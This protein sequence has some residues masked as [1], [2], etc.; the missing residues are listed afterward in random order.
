[1]A[2]SP[3]LGAGGIVLR[4]GGAPL[5]AVV[6]RRKDNAWVLPKGKLKRNESA[7]AAAEREVQEE[8]GHDVVVHE[9]VGAISYTANRKPK[10]V[11]FWRM[12]AEDGAAR[13]LSKDIRAVKWLPLNSA[14]KKLRD[15][16]EQVFLRNVAERVLAN[17]SPSAPEDASA[18]EI[19]Q[20]NLPAE[21]PPDQPTALMLPI[22]EPSIGP[23]ASTRDERLP[24]LRVAPVA[25]SMPKPSVLPSAPRN[26][27]VITTSAPTPRPGAPAARSAPPGSIEP[28]V[29]L[30]VAAKRAEPL[31][32]VTKPDGA[33]P[34]GVALIATRAG[35]RLATP[36]SGP[37]AS[38]SAPLRA[39][40]PATPKPQPMGT[41]A[42]PV[43]LTQPERSPKHDPAA[44]P[45]RPNLLGR[46]L[47]WLQGALDRG[48][49]PPQRTAWR[50]HR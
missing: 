37:L 43:T 19:Q 15:P 1:M 27:V 7:I 14:V 11:Q 23:S 45:T 34:S 42:R 6:Q 35:A 36:Q 16:L 26:P 44:Q 50:S 32:T 13:R 22:V 30:P 38:P 49:Q 10:V 12:Q 2:R 31:P 9:F 18:V 28:V 21:L 20:T 41:K 17:T 48:S 4:S 8:T 46:I 5:I 39:P 40:L 47:R 24:E 33:S 3:I 29:S 25:E